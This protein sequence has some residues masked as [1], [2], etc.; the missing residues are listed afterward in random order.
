MCLVNP[1]QGKAGY[2]KPIQIPTPAHLYAEWGPENPRTLDETSRI[3]K[4][5]WVCA[6]GHEWWTQLKIRAT[7]GTGCPHCARK[8]QGLVRRGS[9]YDRLREQWSEENEHTIENTHTKA[10]AKW[11]CDQGHIWETSINARLSTGVECTRCSAKRSRVECDMHDII[12]SIRPDAVNNHYGILPGRGATVDSYVPSLGI[13]F[14]MNGL[15]WHSEACNKGPKTHYERYADAREAGVRLIQI[16]EDDWR[17]NRAAVEGLIKHKLGAATRLKGAR[18]YRVQEVSPTRARGFL[19]GRHLQGFVGATKHLALVD[20]RTDEIVAL[21]SATRRRDCVMIDRFAVAGSVSGGFQKLLKQVKAEWPGINIVTFSHND[22]SNGDVY[23]QAGFV[24]EYDFAREYYY[25]SK[26]G[27]R[28][29]HRRRYQV[30]KFYEN[31]GLHSPRPGMSERELAE[32][33]DL[34]R[35]WSSGNAKWVL[36]C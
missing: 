26:G 34:L 25:I 3:T 10:R 20:P 13:A 27:T 33:N 22:I 21:L 4:C 35:V 11:R 16:W 2:G 5:H 1:K 19:Q 29:E 17:Y 18:S 15:Y 28:R 9:G 32:A 24:K 7:R 31:P 6:E 8:T 12:K 36:R 23:E 30:S 14:E